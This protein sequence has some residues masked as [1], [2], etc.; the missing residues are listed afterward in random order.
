MRSA[1]CVLITKPVRTTPD[2]TGRHRPPSNGRI[3]RY[4]DLKVRKPTNELGV[5]TGEQMRRFVDHLAAD[6]LVAVWRLLLTT[7]MRR[8]ELLGTRW[9]DLHITAGRLTIRQT[10][11]MVD[12]QPEQGTPKSTA[13]G[14]T[15]S[16]DAGTMAALRQWK[17]QQAAERLAIGGAWRGDADLIVTE[18]DGAPVHP[19]MFSRRFK[20]H[21][22]AC[23]LPAIR[24]H[25]T[26]HSYATV[27]LAAG[28][29]VKVLSQRLGHADI[30]VTLRI[31]AHVMPGDDEA[32]A[33]LAANAILG[34][35]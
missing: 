7:G 24:L 9:R 11:T 10:M 1:F 27:A 8:G 15:I 32:A 29:P 34:K 28:V 5:W 35:L 23:G 19:Q 17:R 25:D 21:A 33:T 22:K 3:S 12:G 31:Y 26:R 4:C 20:A 6:R 16:I 14:R 2:G 13:G 18:T 30:G